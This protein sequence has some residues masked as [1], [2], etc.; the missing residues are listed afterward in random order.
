MCIR[1]R[2]PSDAG[3]KAKKP[4][5]KAAAGGKGKMMSIDEKKDKEDVF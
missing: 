4:A 1:D 2:A 3:K 5:A